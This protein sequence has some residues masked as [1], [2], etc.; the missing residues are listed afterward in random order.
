MKL[1]VPL[2][3]VVALLLA[4]YVGVEPLGLRLFVG[5]ALP[6]LA[7]AVFVVGFIWRVVVWARSPVPFRIPTT[8]GQQR[9][10]PWIKSSPLDNPQTTLGVIGRMA[11][12]ILCFRSLFR[13][14]A[15]TV[16]ARANVIHASDKILWAASMVFHW[17]FALVIIRHLR[18]F[19]EPV[20]AFVGW[21]SGLDGFLQIGVPGLLMTG[22]GLLLATLYLLV[23][24]L[25]S[26]QLRYL[27][28]AADYF[29]L[30]LIGA[31][32]VT[33]ILLRHFAKT[34]VASIKTTIMALV[35]F[36]PATDAQ[37]HWL[38]YAHLLLVCVLLIYFPFS[39]LMHAGG[40]FLSPTR[41][42]ANN[43]RM[44]RHINPWNPPFEVYPYEKYEDEFREKM[45]AAGI[46]VEKE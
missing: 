13:N 40:V 42:L 6:Y 31:I 4:A 33:G 30:L 10:L 16:D 36:S 1:T 38:F 37:I 34:D 14:T 29:P 18:F 43:N 45:K 8:C 2:I 17:C 22:I 15:T 11:L 23:R 5:A 39:K 19:T 20:P 32:A 27:S 28:L 24:R 12:E 35:A 3:V 46:P 9:S 7:F 21:V 26:P 44:V 25:A 41:N